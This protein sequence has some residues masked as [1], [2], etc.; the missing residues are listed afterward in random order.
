MYSEHT[1]S[2]VWCAERW[3]EPAMIRV[4]SW[5]GSRVR[6]D[7]VCGAGIDAR[8]SRAARPEET[9]AFR[10]ALRVFLIM[11]VGFLKAGIGLLAMPPRRLGLGVILLAL[12]A[13]AAQRMTVT[14]GP[15]QDIAPI[16]AQV[17]PHLLALRERWATASMAGDAPVSDLLRQV[18]VD[19]PQ[20]PLRLT[21][22]TSHLDVATVV[23]PR[24][25]RPNAYVTRYRLTVRV[26]SPA[27]GTRQTWLQGTG[28]SRSL[29]NPVRAIGDAMTQAVRGFSCR[30]AMLWDARAAEDKGL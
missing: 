21:Y 10:G 19:D 5:V 27:T 8:E 2:C 14:P 12:V 30:L 6:R 28:E 20:A 7:R 24:F 11:V 17:D 4:S 22:V 29:V 25:Y 18:L 9:L 3:R 13:C 1:P 16:P 23:S 26:E 15:L